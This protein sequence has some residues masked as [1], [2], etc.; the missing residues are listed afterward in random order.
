M[1]ERGSY[2]VFSILEE[3]CMSS[4]NIVMSV[5]PPPSAAAAA[6]AAAASVSSS[7]NNRSH[8]ESKGPQSFTSLKVDLHQDINGGFVFSRCLNGAFS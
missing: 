6:S 2:G 7:S 8:S 1:L 3:V 5:Q 4:N